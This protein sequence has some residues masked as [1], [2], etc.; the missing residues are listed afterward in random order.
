MKPTHLPS[1]IKDAWQDNKPFVLFIISQLL[2]LSV[3]K[4]IFYYYNYHFIFS[5]SD[6]ENDLTSLLQL[7]KWSVYFD[8]LTILIINVPLLILLQLTRF[9]PGRLAP[10]FTITLFILINS[11][12]IL[13]NIADI[14]YF[15]FHFQRANADLLYL[16]KN[17]FDQF[18]HLRPMIIMAF[19]L[20]IAGTVFI[21][22]KLHVNFYKS[23]RSGKRCG[24]ATLL[25]MLTLAGLSFFR[26]G[27]EKALV[28]TYPL[29]EI[30]S[31]QLLIV[32]NSFHSFAYSVFRG[33][34][35]L[36]FTNY[37]STAECDSDFP[38]RKRMTPY[39]KSGHPNIVL[40]IMESVPS[41]FFDSSS[42]YKVSMPFFDSLLTKSSFYN[43]A[44]C[45]AHQSNKGIT[46]ILAGL[47]TLPDIPLYHSPFVNMP[48]TR[49]G[50]ALKENDYHS[51]FCIGDEFD[52]FGFAKC[53]HWLG[54]DQYY[55]KEDIPGYTNLPTHPMGIHDGYV[56]DF[57]HWKIND[58]SQP[59]FAVNYN[60]STH[61]P[62]DIPPSFQK[63]FPTGYTKP[64]KAMSYY[65]QSLQQFFTA[66]EK[67]S[68]FRNTVFIFCSDHWLV[69]DDNNTTYNAVSGYRIPIIIYD[70]RTE[71]RK[72]I[73]R[74]VSQFDVMGT[75]LSL[76]GYRDSIITYGS[77]LMDTTTIDP[78]VFSRANASLYQVSDSAFILG[79]DP[80]GN[81][82]EFL[83]HYTK[84]I[85]LQD[86]LLLVDSFATMREAL[87]KK[88]Q[89]FL[90]KAGMQY[91]GDK[92]K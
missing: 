67:E 1:P 82:A 11:A 38:I 47:P 59:F 78:V 9:I 18:F 16:L 31:K 30:N 89:A 91:N 52:N 83:Y 61:Y 25:I 56:L 41:D 62:Y 27:V 3:L 15:R 81:K 35:E 92:F 39:Q 74:K 32:Q 33:G 80:S 7:I 24:L 10:S 58:V 63:T 90:Q 13:L 2:I 26:A 51:F 46:A 23:F 72:V 42:R 87:T 19:L 70:A 57:M 12:A 45:F 29:T 44:F 71:E 48:V 20:V 73:P 60:I 54:F 65:D 55:C 4:I 66:A 49:I 36:V 28:P 21:N 75:I 17:P 77:S 84:D 40:F 85:E 64:M 53:V 5:P 86:N 69:P 37:M 68:W 50:A 43:N 88:M 22:R 8:L 6:K 14:F 79:F 34:R 76:S